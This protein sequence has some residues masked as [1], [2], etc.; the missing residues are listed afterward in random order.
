M[1][2]S[3]FPKINVNDYQTDGKHKNP[4]KYEW[5]EDTWITNYWDCCKPSCSWQDKGNVDKP[6]KACLPDGSA[7]D[8]NEGSVC[9]NGLAGSCESH[10]PFVAAD[11]LSYGFAAAAAGPSKYLQGDKN[12]GQCFE[13]VFTDKIHD[14]TWGGAHRNA[15][16]KSHIVQVTNIGYDVQGDHSFDLQVPGGGMGKFTK[17]CATQYQGFSPLAF[18][19]QGDCGK[20]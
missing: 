19:G 3:K 12:C 11:G 6:I 5:I 20:G 2:D 14:G 8:K 4:S 13:L 10:Q 17:G 7:A 9:E 16:G 15:V 1:D 18:D